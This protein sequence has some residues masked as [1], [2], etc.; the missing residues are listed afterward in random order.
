MTTNSS[1]TSSSTRPHTAYTARKGPTVRASTSSRDSGCSGRRPA[2]SM[3]STSAATSADQAEHEHHG[4]GDGAHAPEQHRDVVGQQ[5][6]RE[7]GQEPAAHPGEDRDP[8]PT[9]R[10]GQPRTSTTVPH[11]AGRAA[12][13]RR[14]GTAA[15]RR[16]GGAAPGR[17]AAASPLGVAEDPGRGSVQDRSRSEPSGSTSTQLRSSRTR[18]LITGT[19]CAP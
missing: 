5:G 12:A 17:W 19:R 11:S 2:A 13:W 10:R 1:L 8:Q 4:G 15:G 16:R 6:H 3:V 9:R 7:A 18:A 14:A